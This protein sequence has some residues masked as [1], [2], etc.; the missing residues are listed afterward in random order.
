MGTWIPPKN[1]MQSSSPCLST[2]HCSIIY[3]FTLTNYIFSNGDEVPKSW[4]DYSFSKWMFVG[5]NGWIHYKKKLKLNQTH[6]GFSCHVKPATAKLSHYWFLYHFSNIFSLKKMPYLSLK[7][8]IHIDS[9]V[10]PNSW[11]QA[12]PGFSLLAV[13]SQYI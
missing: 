12:K 13:L 9:F 1:H 3:D 7:L 4:Q 11:V 6:V 5:Q 10:H 8:R 2:L